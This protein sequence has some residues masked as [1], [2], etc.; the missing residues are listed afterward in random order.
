M[1]LSFP[2]FPSEGSSDVIS[3]CG[4]LLFLPQVISP[5]NTQAAQRPHAVLLVKRKQG[6]KRVPKER[7]GI[8]DGTEKWERYRKEEEEME[9][10]VAEY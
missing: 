6:N 9:E 4:K 3:L 2:A 10:R 8:G 1:T 7:K 5:K